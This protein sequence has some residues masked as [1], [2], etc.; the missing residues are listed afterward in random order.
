MCIYSKWEALFSIIA[1]L[2]SIFYLLL[3]G[4]INYLCFFPSQSKQ[5]WRYLGWVKNCI[6]GPTE[7][8]FNI[9]PHLGGHEYLH[10]LS[11][12]AVFINTFKTRTWVLVVWLIKM[13]FKTQILMWMLYGYIHLE[14]LYEWWCYTMVT[15][16]LWNCFK[17]QDKDTLLKLKSL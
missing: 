2:N 14:E 1:N 5:I 11:S 17:L 9:Q 6:I 3:F 16:S 13:M 12:A 15:C 8:V 10:A 7:G 4:I